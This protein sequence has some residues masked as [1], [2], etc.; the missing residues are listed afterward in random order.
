M[1]ERAIVFNCGRDELIGILHCPRKTT[2]NRAIVLVVGGPQYRI[3]S[4]R[5]FVL[6]A[7]ALA[8]SGIPV[9][10]FDYRGMGDSSGDLVG[11]TGIEQDIRCAID[12]A[13]AHLRDVR[14]IALWGLCDA[15]TAIA[16]YAGL[17]ERVS[18]IMLVNPWVRTASGEAST[19][20]RTYYRARLFDGKAWNVLLLSPR[21][22]LTAAASLLANLH[23][24]V[25]RT[26]DDLLMAP[27]LGA[28]HLPEGDLPSRFFSG[29]ARFKGKATIVIC[30]K[31]LTA[32]EFQ[33]AATSNPSYHKILRTDNI[34]RLTLTGADHTFSR[35][36]WRETIIQWTRDWSHQ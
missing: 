7:R 16:M 3:G 14:E 29:L 8:S 10:R 11:F 20:I 36:M 35:S 28:Y 21:R 19:L 34:D 15:A 33:Q 17:D 22:L 6:L 32:Q 2:V 4:H 30:E 18:R 1:D 31:D 24:S 5:Q 27:S 9:F 12:T 13:L 25:L 26:K 23:R